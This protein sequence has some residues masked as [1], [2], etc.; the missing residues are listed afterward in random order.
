MY[1]A[2]SVVETSRNGGLRSSTLCLSPPVCLAP[3]PSLISWDRSRAED[4]MRNCVMCEFTAMMAE[5]GGE[6]NC[7]VDE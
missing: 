2:L 6:W 4:A 3:S 5:M 1:D 7:I